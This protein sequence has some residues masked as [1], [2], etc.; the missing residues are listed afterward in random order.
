[1]NN[2]KP[3]WVPTCN[4]FVAFLD[5][6]GFQ[7]L[8]SRKTHKEVLKIMERFRNII[9]II[10]QSAVDQLKG[11]TEIY[12][13]QDTIIWPVIFSDSVLL[14]S[15]DDSIESAIN[16][17]TRVETTIRQSI[18]LGIPIKASIAYG[19]QTADF[20]KS[21]YFGRPLID[22]WHLQNEIL[23]YGAVL[24]HT[25]EKYLIDN[26]V[27]SIYGDSIFLNYHTP[28]K[29]GNISHYLLNWVNDP[30]RVK[31]LLM[32]LRCNVSG[33]SRIYIDNTISFVDF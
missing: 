4:R 16:I 19:E 8:I 22:A 3:V 27:F 10:E 26:Q 1:M 2:Q 14:C 29:Q 7:E 13:F 5:I 28:L 18:A 15:S 32:N 25:F 30:D 23:L 12:L 9:D 24:H 17:S 20:K 31:E 11:N 21:L 33:S 6:M